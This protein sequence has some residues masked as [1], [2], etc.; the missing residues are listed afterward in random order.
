M[1]P[2]PSLKTA[3]ACGRDRAAISGGQCDIVCREESNGQDDYVRVKSR[4]RTAI[5]L[6]ILRVEQRSDE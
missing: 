1:A 2:A 3:R 4:C 5:S 6:L